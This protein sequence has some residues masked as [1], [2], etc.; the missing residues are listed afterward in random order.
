MET[1]IRSI[2][3]ALAC[4]PMVAGAQ[5]FPA[6]HEIVRGRVVSDSGLAVRAADIVVTPHH[7]PRRRS[8]VAPTRAALLH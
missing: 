3:I 5:Q 6:R 4:L 1:P 7:G 8:R 2:L